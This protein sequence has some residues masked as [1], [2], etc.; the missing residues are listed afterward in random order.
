MLADPPRVTTE[1]LPVMAPAGT[2]AV[3]CVLEL[4]MNVA[5]LVPNLTKVVTAVMPSRLPVD[6]KF[7]MV[8]VV[9]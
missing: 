9:N 7:Y 6:A 5:I 3:T 4:M 2:V 8:E 1:I